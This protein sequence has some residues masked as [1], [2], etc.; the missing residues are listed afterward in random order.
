MAKKCSEQR[1]NEF[2]LIKTKMIEQ[3]KLKT[4]MMEQIKTKMGWANKWLK[5]LEQTYNMLKDLVK[6]LEKELKGT[7]L[8]L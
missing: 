2:E 5:Q 4:K 6:Q 7:K 8:K 1:S 3:I